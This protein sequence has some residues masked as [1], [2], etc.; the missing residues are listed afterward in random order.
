MRKVL[1]LTCLFLALSTAQ[2]GAVSRYDTA[3]AYFSPDKSRYA[4]VKHERKQKQEVFEAKFKNAPFNKVMDFLARQYGIKFVFEGTGSALP[5]SAGTASSSTGSTGK[6]VTVGVT[7][8]VPSL[9]ASPVLSSKPANQSQYSAPVTLFV[10]AKTVDDLVEKVCQA[11]DYY[12]EKVGDYWRV[13]PYEMAKFD[14]PS[15]FI[16][17]VGEQSSSAGAYQYA[18]ADKLFTD[19][20]KSLLSPEGKIVRSGAGYVVI[21]DKPSNVKRI[22]RIITEELAHIQPIKLSIKVI[23]VDLNKDNEAGIDWNAVLHKAGGILTVGSSFATNSV[24]GNAFS[25]ALNRS[26]LSALLKVLSKYGNVHVVKEWSTVAIAGTPLF[27][28]SVTKVPWF[29]QSISQNAQTSE[30]TT[31]VNFEE[32]GLKISVLPEVVDDGVVKGSIYT[33]VSSLL[34]FQ[35]DGKGDKAPETSVSNALVNFS[36]PFGKSIIVS[37]LKE[38]KVDRGHEGI[39]VLSSLPFIGGL[40]GYK[41]AKKETSEIIVVVTPEPVN[42]E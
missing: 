33:E 26:N 1:T 34:G 6:V 40:F 36:V 38:E 22:S 20:I 8:A 19:Q 29:Q 28:N 7:K 25:F 27:T 17:K 2:S 21:V 32:V 37:G 10:T 15:L 12:C 5:A 41:Y 39:P 4:V 24:T 23:R 30:V 11:A 3:S 13:S 35:D 14:L 31:Q 9:P 18:Y 16:T 42:Q